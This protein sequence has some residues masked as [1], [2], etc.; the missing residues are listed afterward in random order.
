[1][2]LLDVYKELNTE[3]KCLGFLEHM[4]WPE[5][6]KCLSCNSDRVSN[7][8]STG[9]KNRKTGKV[10]PDR[11]LYQCNDC[12][13]QFTATTGTVYHDT[14]LPLSK[15]FLAIALITE[16]KKGIS[17]NQLKRALGV[18]YRTA[19]YLAHRIRKAM[20]EANPPKMKGIVEVDETYIGGKHRGHKGKMK[21]K[22]VVVG[23]RERGGPLRL[24][25][26]PDNKADTLYQVIA[27]HV[28]KNVETIMTDENPAYSFQLTQ[29]HRT[30]HERIK[31]K[32]KIYVR[33]NVHTNTVE[34]A[35]S[36]F[37]RGLTGAF[38]KVSLKH[39]QRYLN[40]FSFRFNNRKAADLFGMT[41]R[42]MALAGNLPYAQLVE[43][44]AFTPFVRPKR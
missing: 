5:G 12:R 8:V 41:V 44:N 6:V 32:D 2:N 13:F 38:H 33:G 4:R 11:H 17:A 24:V 9:K 26:T 42:R 29:F 37:K 43:E 16:S 18:Q 15:W 25:Q 21:S 35:F 36:L 14:H 27:D 23:V 19:W 22:D 1:M 10:G 40:E 34:S 7:I 31:H 28:D 30:P 20:V 3:A 39:L